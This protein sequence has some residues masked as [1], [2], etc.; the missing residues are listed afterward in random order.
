MRIASL[1]PEF[2]ACVDR[3]ARV[4]SGGASAVFA[5]TLIRTE[6][7]GSE[8]IDFPARDIQ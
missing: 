6:S 2:Y 4:S 1:D 7:I 5:N 8:S 3:H